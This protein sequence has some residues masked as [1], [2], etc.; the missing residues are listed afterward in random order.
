MF[1]LCFCY[2]DISS[3]HALPIVQ[4]SCVIMEADKSSAAGADVMQ[5][6]MARLGSCRLLLAESTDDIQKAA[7]SRLQADAAARLLERAAG[8]LTDEQKADVCVAI[9]RAKFMNADS[10][11]LQ[12]IL[13]SLKGL[14]A[15][16][17]LMQCFESVIN[18]FSES[19]WSILFS[20]ASMLEKRQ[21]VILRLIELGCERPSEP[22]LKRSAAMLQLVGASASPQTAAQVMTPAQMK[23][24][25]QDL[26]QEFKR[27]LK[28]W[29]DKYAVLTPPWGTQRLPDKADGFLHLIDHSTTLRNGK[30]VRCK[31]KWEDILGTESA[32][33]CRGA[34]SLKSSLN[35]ALLGAQTAPLDITT[36]LQMGAMGQMGQMGQMLRG[37]MMELSQQQS[38]QNQQ[39][40]ESVLQMSGWNP[41]Q[42]DVPALTDSSLQQSS[43]GFVGNI[44]GGRLLLGAGRTPPNTTPASASQH[45]SASQPCDH[46]ANSSQRNSDSQA[47]VRGEEEIDSPPQG[48]LALQD[49]PRTDHTSKE[50]AEIH[51]AK[52]QVP[53]T[54]GASAAVSLLA[55]L[56]SRDRSKAGRKKKAKTAEVASTPAATIKQERLCEVEE[57]APVT[58]KIK[59]KKKRAAKEVATVL[60][61]VPDPAK[62]DIPNRKR[63]RPPKVAP[64]AK[65]KAKSMPKAHAEAKAA[66]AKAT[67]RTRPVYGAAPNPVTGLG[68]SKCRYAP[69]GCTTCMTRLL[70]K[71]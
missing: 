30:P 36:S 37:C 52:K 14:Q 16:E 70:S 31:L 66:A 61:T 71:R 19:E 9:L 41:R 56:E 54:T 67:A 18:W 26:R 12:K 64:K 62:E 40:M 29:K 10:Q 13:T 23:L 24:M 58:V 53:A 7:V 44:A 21:L 20:Q 45:P 59:R 46:G 65:P 57:L 47:M 17:W 51:T 5:A 4:L 22:T 69:R 28:C 6:L 3:W 38:L 39:F 8:S 43:A 60:P 68:C 49:M 42:T 35:T 1:L 48:Q 11:R 34:G 50:D 32:M 15:K 25:V 55:L 33:R 27:Q 2:I 63:G